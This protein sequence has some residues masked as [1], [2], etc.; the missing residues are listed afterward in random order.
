MI[1]RWLALAGAAEALF[2]RETYGLV[3]L[4]AGSGIT[5]AG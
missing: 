3:F 1:G 2:I 5:P 4:W